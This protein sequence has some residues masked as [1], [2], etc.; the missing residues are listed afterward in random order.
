MVLGI[1]IL[2]LLAKWFGV[3]L[4]TFYMKLT[5]QVEIL[6]WFLNP[7]TIAFAIPLYRRNDVVKFW[8]EIVLSLIIGMIIS[9]FIIYYVSKL[10]GLNNQ[11]IASVAGRYYCYC[12]AYCWRHWWYSSRYCDGM[13]HQCRLI[14]ALADFDQGLRWFV[15]QLVL[16]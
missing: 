10:L 5:S 9:L 15:T 12:D 14:Y 2:W 6:F 16:V 7:A 13:Y 11:M 1:F 8:L 4:P 3:T